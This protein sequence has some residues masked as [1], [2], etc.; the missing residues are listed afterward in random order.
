MKSNIVQYVV[1]LCSIKYSYPRLCNESDGA[2]ICGP[3]QTKLYGNNVEID[4]T[5]KLGTC[6]ETYG[7]IL[8]ASSSPV[9][10]LE[11]PPSI[12]HH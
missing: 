11:T 2:M 8:L 3:K 6:M 9:K 12:P 5:M 1:A 10:A 7:E 4:G